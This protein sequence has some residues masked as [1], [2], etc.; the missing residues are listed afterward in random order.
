M[1]TG[2]RAGIPLPLNN[3]YAYVLNEVKR[4]TLIQPPWKKVFETPYKAVPVKN[5]YW[6]ITDLLRTLTPDIIHNPLL[7]KNKTQPHLETS[8]LVASKN[9]PA[10]PHADATGSVFI[11]PRKN[12]GFCV[13]IVVLMFLYFGN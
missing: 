5:K 11:N 1:G 9:A 10:I 7:T 4:A 3:G 12:E 13:E 6:A 8:L 2:E